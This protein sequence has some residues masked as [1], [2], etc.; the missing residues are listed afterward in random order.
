MATTARRSARYATACATLCAYAVAAQG[1]KTPNI[2]MVVAD[3]LGYADLGY[4]NNRTE[5]PTID[6]LA[7]QG[8]KLRDYCAFSHRHG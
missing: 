3:D 6:R 5:T 1:Q 7:G 8:V 2:L 4:K